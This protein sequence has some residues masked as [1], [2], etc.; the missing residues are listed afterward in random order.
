[1]VV[2]VVVSSVWEGGGGWHELD[3]TIGHVELTSSL[4]PYK[5]LHAVKKNCSV[6]VIYGINQLPAPI[7]STACI[8]EKKKL[9]CISME[10]KTLCPHACTA[11]YGVNQP[12]TSE[13]ACITSTTCIG[14]A[15][16]GVGPVRALQHMLSMH[17]FHSH[18]SHDSRF[19]M[20]LIESPE[21]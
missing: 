13:L 7:Q 20:Q 4:P 9:Q 18:I 21:V 17:Y 6:S 1:M 3:G 16:T 15:Q 5:A 11:A 8:E 12:T 2:V 19:I 14:N 10:L